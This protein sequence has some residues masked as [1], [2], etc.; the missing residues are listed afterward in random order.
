MKRIR[1][2]IIDDSATVRQV[3]TQVLGSAPDIEVIAT[4]ADPLFA[5]RK[6][7]KDWPD[8][9]VLDL[10]MPRM[11]GLTFLR[12]LMAEHPTPVVICSSL[13]EHNAEVTLQA[14]AV[15][16]VTVVTK[17]KADV[18]AFLRDAADDVI[19]AVRAAA[20]ARLHDA[21]SREGPRLSAPVAGPD[22]TREPL[23]GPAPFEP[24]SDIKDT[25]ERIVAIGTSTGGTTALEFVL[26]Q[27][28]RA[29]P[30]IAIVQHMPEKFT[31]T[32]AQRLNQVCDIEVR[33]ARHGDRLHPGLALIAP[34][35]QH[36]Q[37]RRNGAFYVVDVQPGPP[38]NRHCPS[39][40]VLFRSVAK[41]VGR[42]ALGIILT[43]MGDDGAR[44]LL[45]MREAGAPTIGQDEASCVV[46]GM[47]KE[48]ARM[49]ACAQVLPLDRMADA[50]GAYGKKAL[51]L[52][53]TEPG[54]P[55]EN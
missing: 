51:R 19:S 21:S 7:N 3:L 12:K 40:D 47:P 2:M 17:P 24:P 31:A 25:T 16:A 33:E 37:V 52:A 43:G 20:K 48:A 30:G 11:D 34:G 28:D 23:R 27:L 36:M 22:P 4:A 39:V 44:G 46:Y 38:V 6:M 13:A 35:R 55:G 45:A 26:R 9:I 1:T 53:K 49:G 50:I 32:F 54:G 15:G 42:N 18:G 8:V 10:E 41:N 29:V 5:I 14:L